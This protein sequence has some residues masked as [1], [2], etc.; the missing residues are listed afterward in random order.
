VS[1]ER[2]VLDVNIQEGYMKALR[3]VTPLEVMSDEIE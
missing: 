3:I 2:K 1:R